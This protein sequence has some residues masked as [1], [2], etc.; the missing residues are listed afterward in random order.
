MAHATGWGC[1]KILCWHA[2][3]T[4]RTWAQ[5]GHLHLG[6]VST[7]IITQVLVPTLGGPHWRAMPWGSLEW[8]LTLLGT[9]WGH[10]GL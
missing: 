10:D 9:P 5:K 8:P 7:P 3:S 1:W 2:T 6:L 4:P